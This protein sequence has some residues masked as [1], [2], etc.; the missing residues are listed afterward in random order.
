MLVACH[1]A[2]EPLTSN[3]LAFAWFWDGSRDDTSR[4]LA[5][6]LSASLCAGIGGAAG[7]ADLGGFHFAYRPLSGNA[8]RV[9]AW[10]PA[11]LESGAIVAF[12][13]YIDNPAKLTA[14]L[15]GDPADLA[16]LY[17]RAVER[18][19]SQADIRVIGEYCA[20]VA[21]PDHRR[22]RLSRSPL[23]APPLVYHH[24]PARGIAAA[25]VP[26]ALF[27]AGVE[28]RLDR[29]KVADSAWMN[30][31]AQENS[32][33]HGVRRVPLG[34]T[35]TIDADS[36]SGGCKLDRY[37]DVVALPDVR[38]P[39]DADYIARAGELLDEGVRA[40][41]AGAKRPGVTLSS[42]LDTP[43]VATRVLEQLPP[44]QRLPSFTFRPEAG[45]DG[46]APTGMNGDEG[47][48]VEAFAAMH[49]RL[50]P[51]FA[52]NA[53]YGHDH[54]WPEMFHAMGGA[55]SGLCNMYVLHGVWEA[56]RREGCDRLLLAEWGNYTFSDKGEWGFV[57]YLL[58][59]RW[60]QL[61]RALRDHPHD[62]RSM[63][64]KFVALC[65]V[66]LLPYPAWRLMKRLVHAGEL[67]PRELMSPLNPDYRAATGVEDRANAR[68]SSFGRYQPR[69][70][71]EARALLFAN[72]DGESAE[73]FQA[74]EQLY[75][76]AHRDPMSYRPFVEFCMGLPTRMFLR[77]GQMRW[78][79]KQLARGIMPEH[80]RA[81]SL[82]GRWDADWHL[83]IG[84]R[85]TELRAEFE[86][87]AAHPTLGPMIDTARMIAALDDFPPQTSTDPQVWMEVEMGIPRALL[88]ARFVDF[89]ERS[90]RI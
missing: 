82:N 46:I 42:G 65:L 75:G 26:R 8:A 81:N 5:Q 22:V 87:I 39:S 15:G 60:I 84:R 17:G 70:G 43:Q 89:V 86:R 66:P 27:A 71:R 51:H 54:R 35:V 19:G 78:L 30:Y 18:W 37:Y 88:T 57:E 7:H 23:K 1:A 24:D 61:Y 33:F 31:T 3:L 49:P 40:V 56:A 14:E 38:L 62:R 2:P 36:A 44:G 58:T 69:N 34:C 85:R 47:P 74:F 21:W 12:H 10:R 59:G 48:M 80:Q 13:G 83:R 79:A 28:E 45:W 6:R 72:A 68:A 20:V 32:W 52:D 76:V 77:D 9:R 64:R 55:P 53:G 25:S 90:N 11:K 4:N 29:G 73:I 41:L 63:S 50:D 16:A 67:L